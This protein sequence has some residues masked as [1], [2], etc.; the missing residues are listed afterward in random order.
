MIKK[1]EFNYEIYSKL[2]KTIWSEEFD[3]LQEF[4][5]CVTHNQDSSEDMHWVKSPDQDIP[6]YDEMYN[7]IALYLWRSLN[8]FE[9]RRNYLGDLLHG[10]LD[11]AS[12]ED[13]GIELKQIWYNEVS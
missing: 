10:E 13:I 2:V 7:V 11:S 1:E 6:D 9:P 8:I 3:R 4:V 12:V 5:F